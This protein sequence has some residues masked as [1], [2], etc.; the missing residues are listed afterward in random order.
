MGLKIGILGLGGFGQGFVKLYQAHPDVDE[1]VL[2]ELRTEVLAEVA[3]EHGISRTTTDFDEMLKMDDLDGVAIYTQRWNHAPYAIKALRAGKHVY[4]AVPAAVTL[5]EL[6]ELVDTVKETGLVYALGETSFY[7]PQNLYCRERFAKGDFGRYVYGEG[8]YYHDMSHWFYAPFFQSNGP[9]WRRKASVPPIWYPTHSLCHVLGVTMSRCTKVS[10]F[11]WVDDHADGIFDKEL[12][13]FD[14][15]WSNQSALFRTADG[16]MARINEFRRTAAGEG[17][18]QIFG[19]RGAYH[20]MPNPYGGEVSVADQIHGGDAKRQG[21]MNAVWCQKVVNRSEFKEDGTYNYEEAPWLHSKYKEDLS[22]LFDHSGVDISDFNLHG[23]PR[24]YIGR[25]HLGITR[26]H[27]YWRLPKEYVGLPNGH[28]GSHQFLVHDYLQAIVEDKL[29]P[30]HVWFSARINAPGIVAH[31]S[32]KREGEC[33]D[34]P[35]FGKPPA[36]KTCIDP[37]VDLKD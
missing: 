9:D 33:L 15:P 3:K 24:E 28:A 20:E 1:V 27:P 17:R 16:G 36:D 11:G 23:L 7:R 26:M 14:N 4:S 18:Q 12:S 21:Q 35:D 29:P 6:H 13:D 8:H 2:C 32:C 5:E 25:K 10:C 34:I 22:W 31:E 37:L 30:N 19:V